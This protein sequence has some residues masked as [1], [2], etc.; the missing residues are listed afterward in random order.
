MQFFPVEYSTLSAK[1]LLQ[2]I[3]TNYYIDSDSSTTF[4]KRG[5]NDTY[6]IAINGR[7]NVQEEKRA[8]LAG[9]AGVKSLGREKKVS[10]KKF[11]LRIYK[12]K[13]RTIESIETE[14]KLLTYLKE[15][16][17]SVSYPVYDKQSKFIQTIPAPEG[18]RYAVLFSFA[19]GSQ[20]RK[21]SVDQ[22]YLLGIETGKIHSF[23]KNKS[24]GT[25]AHNY[26]IETQ[27]NITLTTIRPLLIN[28]I[29]QYN[30]LLQLKNDFIGLF[31]SI[32]KNELRTGICHGDLQAENFHITSDNQFT[33]FDF[34]FFGTGYLA[35]DIGVF[36]WYDHKNKP[37]EIVRAFLKGYQTQEKV[38][39]T[40]LKLIP[41][42]STLRA[43]FQMTLY[44]K[45]NDGK[46]L[47][48]WSSQQIADFIMKINRWQEEHK[49]TTNYE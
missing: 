19:E 41:Y 46:Q 40:E 12:H 47:P 37:P 21:L 25:T 11:I 22:S 2:L 28:H 23:T 20:I 16:N 13:W 5:F 29:D 36:M 7:E 26:D 1:A 39:A 15:N 43:L 44:C 14:L 49:N 17:I 45:I 3:V 30:Y 31:K 10:S 6:L 38:S 48:L 9:L 42:F 4:L 18:I 8:N 34:D 27:F 24:F 33:F 32:D 35:Y